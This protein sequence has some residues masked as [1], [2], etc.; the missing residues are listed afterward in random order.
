LNLPTLLL[1][2][3]KDFACNIETQRYL[4]SL[5][6]GSKLV[7]FEGAGHVPAMARPAE[8]AAAIKDH[9]G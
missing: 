5:I 3:E 8:V 4:Q 2:G 6:P 1:H 9:F 7:V